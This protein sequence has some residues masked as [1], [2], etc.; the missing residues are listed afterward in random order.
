MTG[1]CATFSKS[2]LFSSSSFLLLMQCTL[3]VWIS[4]CNTA[5]VGSREAKV[6]VAFHLSKLPVRGLEDVVLK[7]IELWIGVTW[8]TGTCARDSGH[9]IALISTRQ[10]T[11]SRIS[12]VWMRQ[13]FLS[14]RQRLST[15]PEV[16]T[17]PAGQRD[18]EVP[19]NG[20]CGKF[21]LPLGAGAASTHSRPAGRLK[22]MRKSVEITAV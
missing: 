20:V 9:S 10:R 1:A 3:A 21:R 5:D 8:K 16:I 18:S 19:E 7:R 2:V 14:T 13:A 11:D 4:T 22:M 6:R 12:R 17:S 15:N